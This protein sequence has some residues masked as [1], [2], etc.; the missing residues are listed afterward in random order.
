[1]K[2]EFHNSYLDSDIFEIKKNNYTEE[3]A[4]FCDT[5]FIELQDYFRIGNVKIV[6][7]KGIVEFWDKEHNCNWVKID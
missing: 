3:I 7:N 6:K 2:C 1:M 4:I 5:I